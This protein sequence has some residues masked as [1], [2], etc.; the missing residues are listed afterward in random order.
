MSR[1]EG[2][3]QRALLLIQNHIRAGGRL[4]LFL[5]YDG[6]LVPI[7]LTPDQAIPDPDL[8]RLLTDLA[9]A[10]HLRV[11][12][13][14][15]RP[16]ASLQALLPV[17][18]LIL[19]GLYGIEIQMPDRTVLRR[20]D[21]AN[22]AETVARIK[23]AWTRLVGSRAGFLVEDKGLAVAL[24]AR[25]ASPTDADDV[26]S[27]AEALVGPLPR[28]QFRVLGGDRFLEV[29][30]SAAHK[31]RSVEWLLEHGNFPDA[32]PVYLGD[33]DKDEEAFVIVRE[34]GGI[35]IIVGSREPTTNALIRL[36]SPRQAR[37]LLRH[38]AT[39]H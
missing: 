9:N 18:G 21:V 28:E 33:D 1:L 23:A 37:E 27:R 30:P 31:G 11:A 26:L 7:A 19:A 32:L 13:L 14:S 5:D 2:S 20:A 6:T 29:A 17:P 25:H 38:L 16:L 34:R 39:Y 22:F 15:G 4:W 24:H 8:L 36:P 12:I 35:P 10:Q 3:E